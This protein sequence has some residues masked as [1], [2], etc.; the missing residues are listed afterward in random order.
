MPS[1]KYFTKHLQ[2]TP[3]YMRRL[4]KACGKVKLKGKCIFIQKM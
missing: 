3:N 2:I 1:C 4:Q